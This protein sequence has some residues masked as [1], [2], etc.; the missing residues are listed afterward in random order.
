M[1][2]ATLA[3][4]LFGIP[5]ALFVA[6]YYRADETAELERAADAA[7][8]DV[9]ADL[10]HGRSPGELPAPESGTSLALFAADGHLLQGKG[11][12]TA[13]PVVRQALDD[14]AVRQT[15][16]GGQLI[17][18]VPLADGFHA[19][20]AVRAATS[21]TEVYPRILITWLLMLTLDG[22]VLLATWRLARRQA[23]R[24]ADPLEHLSH[25]AYRLGDGDFSVRT[26]PSG[27]PEIDSAGAALD[28]TAERIGDLVDRERA[29]TA[30]ASH[31]L[32]TPLTGLR[33]GLEAALD[34]PT[35]DPHQALVDA[36]AV[37]DR[38]DHTIDDLITLARD[39]TRST[40][41]LPVGALL[42][43]IRT[44]WH[45]RLAQ[46]GRPLQV[47]ADTDLPPSSASTAAIRQILAV[48]I[49]NAAV[50]GLGTV[51]V[52]ARDTNNSVAIDVTDE[53]TQ[54]HRDESTLFQRGTTHGHGIGL[55]LARSLAEAEGGRLRL[56]TRIPTTFTLFLPAAPPLPPDD[57]T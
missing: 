1:A 35:S 13:D 17:V 18:A 29:I 10:F 9:A 32:R 22:L 31:Q 28:R 11:P 15:S 38:L 24:L 44:T 33:L 14:N 47:G 39:T 5:L 2:A 3:T 42:D 36:L 43:E 21:N 54:L 48:L 45:G 40:E 7:A 30:N 34:S 16:T 52:H 27:I 57:V 6:H 8:I 51:T 50:H 46:T 25:A 56:S 37:T 26:Q 55:P 20:Y 12:S 23:R 53:G 4:S 49:D 19:A 41:P